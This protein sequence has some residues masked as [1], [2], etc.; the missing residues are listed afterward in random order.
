MIVTF[1]AFVRALVLEVDPTDV[2]PVARTGS[3]LGSLATARH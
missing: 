3:E 1:T 2:H